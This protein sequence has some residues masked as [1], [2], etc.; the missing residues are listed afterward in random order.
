MARIHSV[1][2]LLMRVGFALLLLNTIGSAF[3]QPPDTLW[4]RR[5]GNQY[6]D[7]ANSIIQTPDGGYAVAGETYIEL[8]FGATNTDAYFVKLNLYGIVMWSRV[9]GWEHSD[10]LSDLLAVDGEYVAVGG[11]GQYPPVQPVP[12]MGWMVRLNSNGDTLWH[13]VLGNQVGNTFL[14]QLIA[15]EDGYY[16]AVGTSWHTTAENS[17][18]F[19]VKFDGDG[20][21]IWTRMYG[22]LGFDDG[23]SVVLAQDSNYVACGIYSAGTLDPSDYFMIKVS[24]EGDSLWSR[25]FGSVDQDEVTEAIARAG[26]GGFFLGGSADRQDTPYIDAWVIRTDDQGNLIWQTLLPA[27]YMLHIESAL[28]TEDDGVI[29]SGYEN[30][31]TGG[32]GMY[33]AKLNSN[34]D[35]VWARSWAH[36]H[37][38]WAT[39][40]IELSDGGYAAVGAT[41]YQP[42]SHNCYAWF[43]RLSPDLTPVSPAGPNIPTELGMSVYPNPFNSAL[44]I[45]LTVP[46][47]HEVTITLYDLLG[48]EVDV[49]HRGMLDNATLSYTTSPSLASGIYFLRAATA[50]QTQMQKVVL[51]K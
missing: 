30:F 15:V 42:F 20:N 23:T 28:A 39:D 4:T 34:G 5:F 40:L 22:G 26:D 45:S 46:L 47:N 19:L 32:S 21:I 3:A 44:G 27:D 14:E 1:F 8:P 50:T 31:S 18:L 29:V 6:D 12:G 41:G 36:E 17:D 10:R 16:V 43:V 49:I 48:R 24:Q 25:T 37:S 11:V 33:M 35:S 2:N 13:R 38:S 9:W 7:F 51:L